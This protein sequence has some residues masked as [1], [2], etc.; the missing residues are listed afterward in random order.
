MRLEIGGR[1]RTAFYERGR[2]GILAPARLASL[3]PI[4]T[5]CLG[6]RTRTPDRDRRRPRLY[7]PMTAFIVLPTIRSVRVGLACRLRPRRARTIYFSPAGARLL[8]RG[9]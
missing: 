5:A 3:R 2:L 4:A 6:E 1:R 7:S 8:L 9:W